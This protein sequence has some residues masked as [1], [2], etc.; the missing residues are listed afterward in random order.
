MTKQQIIDTM[1]SNKISVEDTYV[2]ADRLEWWIID[3]NSTKPINHLVQHWVGTYD[4]E[5]E[6]CFLVG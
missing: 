3:I 5:D 6:D 4:Q 1:K 2:F